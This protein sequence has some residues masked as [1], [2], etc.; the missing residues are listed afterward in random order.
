MVKNGAFR[1]VHVRI[2]IYC[3]HFFSIRG[4]AVPLPVSVTSVHNTYLND[5]CTHTYRLEMSKDNCPCKGYHYALSKVDWIRKKFF[6]LVLSQL[7]KKHMRCYITAD[8]ILNSSLASVRPRE[9]T[10]FFPWR[11]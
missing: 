11:T 8:F 7:K 9:S 10:L 4:T 2:L 3:L 6:S 5:T 1:F